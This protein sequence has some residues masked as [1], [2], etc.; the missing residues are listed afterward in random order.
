MAVLRRVWRRPGRATRAAMR[1]SRTPSRG[2]RIAN[3]SKRIAKSAATDEDT[4]VFLGIALVSLSAGLLFGA[5]YAIGVA[6]AALLMF[7]W[8]LGYWRLSAKRE[9]DE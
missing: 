8:W 3:A 5:E 6:G 2:V 4:Y 7:G 1:H 9:S